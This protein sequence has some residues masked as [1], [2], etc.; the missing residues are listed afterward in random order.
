MNNVKAFFYINLKRLLSGRDKIERQL[1][2]SSCQYIDQEANDYIYKRLCEYDGKN[3]IMMSKLG[4]IELNQMS[5][6]Y[7]NENG[8]KFDDLYLYLKGEMPLVEQH[9]IKGLY[10]NAGVFPYGLEVARK[11]AKLAITDCQEIDILGSYLKAEDILKEKLRNSTKVNLDAFYAPFLW[12]NPW[13]KFLEGK[14]VLVVHPF[15]ESIQYQYNNNR[16]K[17][18]DNPDVLPNF[19]EL[20]CIKAVQSQAGEK[21]PFKDWF[22]ALNYMKSQISSLDF[23]VAI[24]GCGAYGMNLAAHV[25][26]MGKVAIHLGGWVQMLFG[27]YGKRWLEDQPEFAKFV[28]DNWI[29]PNEN[30]R[31]KNS[32]KIEGGAYW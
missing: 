8:Y 5:S 30:E 21:T 11:F 15:T 9:V 24:I 27:V 28:N 31:I 4:S 16:T 26:R 13:S 22:E 19:K 3:G 10:N 25:K 6:T 23:D 17:I 7:L 12:K 18:F 20:I 14:R 32:N 2:N 1:S 29:R